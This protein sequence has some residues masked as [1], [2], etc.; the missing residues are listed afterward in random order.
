MIQLIKRCIGATLAVAT[1][2]VVPSC[3]EPMFDKEGDCEVIHRIRFVYDMNLKWAD[4]FPSE[5]KS[6]NLYAFDRNGRFVKAYTDAGAALAQPGYSM[7]LDLP[8]GSYRFVA[9]CGLQNEGAAEE[10]FTVPQPVPGVTTIEELTC[11]LNTKRTADYPVCSDTELYFLYHGYLEA[12]LED[13]HDG[14]QYEHTVLLTKDTNHIRII[15]QELTSDEDM[16]PGD[17][18]FRIE[19]ANGFMAYNN[20][21]P[22]AGVVTYRP[23]SQLSDEVGVGKI[24]VKDGT[25][26]YVKGV[27]AD[28]SVARLMAAQQ[29]EVMLTI[30]NETSAEKE[31]IARVPLI[32]YALLSKKYYESAYGH[33]MTD[34]EFL[35]REDEYVMTFFLVNDRWLNTHIDIHQWRIVFHN[36][37]VGS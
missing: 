8:A 21:V 29:E 18:S 14:R 36:Y 20:A 3:S 16:K 17:Y 32:Q 25:V 15:L 4:A 12:T 10:S 30:V 24:D 23:W 11:T 5:V 37:D 22:A 34:Q 35:D 1:L 27:V 6:V 13:N 19:A 33:K 26:K 7:L 31:V 9:W 2:L 28:L